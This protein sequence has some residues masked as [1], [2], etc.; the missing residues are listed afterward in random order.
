MLKNL[1]H[2]V[3]NHLPAQIK[4]TAMVRIFGLTK[5]PMLWYLRP[6]VVE[7]DRQKCVIKIP[8]T[9]KS[10]NHLNSMYFGAMAAGADCAAGLFAMKLIMQSG[11]NIALSFKDFHAEFLKRAEGDTLFSCVQGEEISTFVSEVIASGERMNK[12]MIVTATCPDKLGDEPVAQ[13]KLTLSL[14][15]K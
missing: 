8:L 14:K 12:E 4:D 6:S 11:E 13:F 7:M 5:V 15:K 10:K 1:Y 3:E 9:R 2:K